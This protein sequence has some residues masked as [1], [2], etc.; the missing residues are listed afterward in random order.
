MADRQP[1]GVP[2]QEG[3]FEVPD[4]DGHNAALRAQKE[5]YEAMGA[6]AKRTYR[7]NLSLANGVHPTT[8]RT[9]LRELPEDER[10][11]KALSGVPVDATCNDCRFC[12]T[13]SYHTRS[14]VKCKA[15]PLTHGPGSDTRRKWPACTKFQARR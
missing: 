15:V 5:R 4:E 11:V 6:D 12:E 3:L 2:G 14:F 13:F 1:P 10:I 8:H 9:L 7:N